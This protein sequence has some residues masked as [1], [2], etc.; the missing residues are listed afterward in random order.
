MT[1]GRINQV[2]QTLAVILGHV[3]GQEPMVTWLG[4]WSPER[5]LTSAGCRA[6]SLVLGGLALDTR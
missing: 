2:L 1:T 4:R 5:R 3:L 6:P